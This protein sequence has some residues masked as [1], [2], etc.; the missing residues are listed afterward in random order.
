MST[1]QLGAHAP[2]AVGYA[3]WSSSRLAGAGDRGDRRAQLVRDR[4]EQRRVEPLRLA[5]HGC[6]LSGLIQLLALDHQ[7]N[8]I[9]KMSPTA[10]PGQT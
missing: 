9:G 8:L 5:Q 1:A 7:R 10:L 3:V 6:L 2:I 4:V